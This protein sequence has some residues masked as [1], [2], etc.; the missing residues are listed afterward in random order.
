MSKSFEAIHR[1]APDSELKPLP[2][3][4]KYD[5]SR[6]SNILPAIT[7]TSLRDVPEEKLLQ[8]LRKYKEAIG[9]A[10]VNIEGIIPSI[11]MHQ[12][13]LEADYKPTMEGQRRLNPIMKEV[14]NHQVA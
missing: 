11:C 1:G 3:H 2:A 14:V 4:L 5:Y 12:I 10:S 7:P 13:F 9:C 6:E 8:V